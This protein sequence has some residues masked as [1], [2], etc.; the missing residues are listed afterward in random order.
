[1]TQIAAQAMFSYLRACGCADDAAIELIR[2]CAMRAKE[3]N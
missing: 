3:T 2:Y 1:M